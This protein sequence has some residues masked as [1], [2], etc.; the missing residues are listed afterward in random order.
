[1]YDPKEKAVLYAAYKHL[2]GIAKDKDGPCEFPPGTEIDVSGERLTITLPPNTVVSR[3]EGENGDGV[4]YKTATQNLYGWGILYAFVYQ[5]ERILKLF[6]Q[7]KRWRPFLQRMITRIVKHA[8]DTGKTSEEAFESAY[9]Q[10]AKGIK[11]LKAS[12]NVPKRKEPTPRKCPKDAKLPVSLKFG[13]EK[14][15]KAA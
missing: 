8:L 4:C 10:I 12:M 1:M 15:K 5:A 3:N 13:E 7:E 14:K 11:D 2:E 6:R 9:P